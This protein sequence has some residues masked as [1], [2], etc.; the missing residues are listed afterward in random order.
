[1]AVKSLQAL[2]LGTEVI[3]LSHISYGAPRGTMLETSHT[4]F[5]I[6]ADEGNILIDAG[7]SPE[8]V[9]K[10]KAQG[11]QLNVREEDLLPNRV[12]KDTGL[13]LNDMNIVILTHLD[14]DHCGCLPMMPNAQVV[15]QREEYRWGMETPSYAAHRFAHGKTF[16]N[17]AI[18]WKIVDGDTVLMPGISLLFT[19]G[20]TPGH[21][22]LLVQLPKS[23]Y[24][25]IVGDAGDFQKDIEEERIGNFQDAR[26]A[27]LSVKRLKVLGKALKAP[28]LTTH[29][30]D[31]YKKVVKKPPDVYA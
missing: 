28:L 7:W 19:P 5:F 12:K 18:K 31:Y 21:Q 11:A 14:I 10:R 4:A 8:M 23:G 27:W 22:S 6:K 20:H 29:D 13:S 17:P 25:I 30:L 15:I 16:T 24:A 9:E 1:M 26:Q 2:C 3:D